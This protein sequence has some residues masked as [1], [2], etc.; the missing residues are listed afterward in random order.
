MNET[1]RKPGFFRRFFGLLIRSLLL[2]LLLLSLGIGGLYLF[3]EAVRSSNNLRASMDAFESRV[4]LLRSDVDGLMVGDREQRQQLAQLRTDTSQMESQL[5]G[6]ASDLISQNQALAA[7]ETA[8]NTAVSDNEA[9]LD[10]LQDGLIALQ[11]D[12]NTTSSGFDALGG[13]LDAL[14]GRVNSLQQDNQQ[15]RTAVTDD[16][17]AVEALMEETVALV[18]TNSQ[19][20]IQLQRSLRLFR[21]WELITR[22]RL[23]LIEG[24]IGLAQADLNQALAVVEQLI[25]VGEA[26]EDEAMV[27][28]LTAVQTRLNL[29][30]SNLSTSPQL[31]ARDLETAWDL[32]DDMLAERL[33]VEFDLPETAEPDE[34]ESESEIE[35]EEEE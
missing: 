20:M 7:L 1:E 21:V 12:L 22:T 19:E 28:G 34:S 16:V 29:A 23:Q 6:L 11:R 9:A 18:T 15:F 26:E 30:L 13:E 14:E 10:S 2:S 8:L 27:A 3:N 31:A 4:N 35:D 24:N 33:L 25:L 5:D 32:L 17:T